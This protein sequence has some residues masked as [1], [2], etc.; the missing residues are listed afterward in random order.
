[1]PV[2]VLVQVL[3]AAAATA[4]VALLHPRLTDRGAAAVVPHARLD[5]D[6]VESADVV[7]TRGCGETCP[8]SR[9]SATRTGPSATPPAR[10]FPRSGG[11]STTSTSGSAACSPS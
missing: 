6:L 7:V 1:V 4:V 5:D 10:T 8:S 2:F 11:S 3:G 9:A